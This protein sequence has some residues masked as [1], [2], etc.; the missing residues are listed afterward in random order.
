MPQITASTARRSIMRR[1]RSSVDG[2]WATAGMAP[3]P[4]AEIS[5]PISGQNR[6][7]LRIA[8]SGT[9]ISCRAP[10]SRAGAN[11]RFCRVLFVTATSQQTSAINFRVSLPADWGRESRVAIRAN[12]DSAP[13]DYVGESA[14]RGRRK[15][16]SSGDERPWNIHRPHASGVVKARPPLNRRSP[17]GEVDRWPQKDQGGPF[18]NELNEASNILRA[19]RKNWA[20][21][22]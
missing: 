15:K 3:K 17:E 13:P 8:V 16:E 18:R 6:S 9:L 20:S 4:S 22:N 1:A 7:A 2:C 10:D 5:S 21:G 12:P 11:T 14:Q 19:R